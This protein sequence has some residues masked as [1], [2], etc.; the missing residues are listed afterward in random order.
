MHCPS[1]IQN[2][3]SGYNPQIKNFRKLYGKDKVTTD[4]VAA[5]CFEWGKEMVKTRRRKSNVHLHRPHPLLQMYL[6]R[7]H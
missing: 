4:A 2:I 6:G 7:H 3:I 1:W 5:Q